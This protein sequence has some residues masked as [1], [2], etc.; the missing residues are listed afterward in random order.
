M[1][2]NHHRHVATLAQ[3]VPLVGAHP[4]AEMLREARGGS[5]GDGT[6]YGA[7]SGGE[8]EGGG[9]GYDFSALP[10]TCETLALSTALGS[11]QITRQEFFGLG[12]QGL[13][14]EELAGVLTRFKI[15]EDFAVS[16]C[17]TGA[18]APRRPQR[19]PLFPDPG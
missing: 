3:P 15:A 12:G 11:L 5:F 18:P 9:T 16:P 7:S 4:A 19:A 2:G 10:V 14:W 8:E 1:R 17:M 13:I 6:F